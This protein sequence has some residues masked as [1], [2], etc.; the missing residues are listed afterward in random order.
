[1]SNK[2]FKIDSFS[3]PSDF[4]PSKEDN[5]IL[6]VCPIYLTYGALDTPTPINLR[7]SVVLLTTPLSGTGYYILHDGVEGQLLYL[8]SSPTNFNSD[9]IVVVENGRSFDLPF[10]GKDFNP[11][12]TQGVSLLLFTSGSWQIVSGP[13]WIGI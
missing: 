2:N 6:S 9:V 11:F 8:V 5:N 7:S 13:D 4:D 10:K 3:T 12:S 1:M